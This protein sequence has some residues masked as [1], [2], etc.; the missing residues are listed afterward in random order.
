VSKRSPWVPPSDAV[1]AEVVSRYKQGSSMTGLALEYHTAPGRM[2]AFLL[3]IGE[4]IRH[5]GPAGADLTEEDVDCLVESYA[6]GEGWESIKSEYG[7]GWQ[8][9]VR[10]LADRGEKPRPQVVT[11]LAL[12]TP[13]RIR[14]LYC[15]R[16]SDSPSQR[17]IA[18][19]Y[20]T[21]HKTVR[22]HLDRANVPV[23]SEAEQA[24]IDY[25]RGRRHPP[26]WKTSKEVR[27]ANIEKARA[28][29]TSE[30]YSRFASE[31]RPS[32]RKRLKLLCWWC[33]V[34]FERCPCRVLP[35][36]YHFCRRSCY[37][38]GVGYAREADPPARPIILN[39]LR[40]EWEKL[41]NRMAR[42]KQPFRIPTLAD[43]EPLGAPFGADIAE[44]F[45]LVEE[46]TFGP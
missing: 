10:L 12:M 24:R 16:G 5:S 8:R 2:R 1:A 3:A 40:E 33:G 32:R 9:F 20:G 4:T 43:L 27:Q 21:D 38:Q 44:Y 25:E 31:P 11:D 14:E 7:I 19:D 37:L 22:R 26:G 18:R 42:H 15:G 28:G 29:L 17:V 23:R 6:R 45:A 35:Y 13:A 34:R 46:Y 41:Q 39:L 36:K 30:D